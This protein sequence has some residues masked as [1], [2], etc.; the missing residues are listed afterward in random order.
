MTGNDRFRGAGEVVFVTGSFWYAGAA[1]AAAV[2]T[3]DVLERED[4]PARL[5]AAGTRFVEGLIGSAARHGY[6]VTLSGPPVMPLMQFAGDT[7]AKLGE[8]FCQQALARGVYL[9]NKH[10]M[11]LNL[12]HTDAVIDEALEAIDAAFAALPGATPA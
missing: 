7:E 5:H 12:A 4:G 11:F 1:M 6:E 9:H 3:L 2:A 8:A 10:N